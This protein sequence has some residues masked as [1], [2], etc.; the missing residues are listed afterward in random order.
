MDLWESDKYAKLS[1]DLYDGLDEDMMVATL[2]PVVIFHGLFDHKG[3]WADIAKSIADKSVRKVY[4]LDMR[5]HG[6]SPKMAS[7]T[8]D[9]N[10]NDLGMFLKKINE[11]VILIGHSLGGTTA[12]EIAFKK[13]HLVKQLILIDVSPL[14]YPANEETEVSYLID[15]IRTVLNIINSTEEFCKLNSVLEKY[16]QKYIK[17]VTL[18][19]MILSNVKKENDK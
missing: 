9:A 13:P 18:C 1:Y 10:V 8:H 16:F 6:D 11:P 2:P 7:M 5:N 3:N 19:K 4:V 17:N 12:M 15:Q 14:R